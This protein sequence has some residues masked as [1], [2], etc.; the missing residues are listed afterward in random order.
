MFCC[1]TRE[2]FSTNCSS[3]IRATIP[4]DA[5]SVPHYSDHIQPFG[6]SATQSIDRPPTPNSFEEYLEY[7]WIH[8]SH[9][10]MDLEENRDISQLIKKF[11]LLKQCNQKLEENVRQKKEQLQQYK[12]LNFSIKSQ[13]LPEYTNKLVDTNTEVNN[14][15]STMSNLSNIQQQQLGETKPMSK[16]SVN[17]SLTN[18]LAASQLSTDDKVKEFVMTSQS[19]INSNTTSQFMNCHPK[20]GN[21]ITTQLSSGS[22]S[23]SGQSYLTQSVTKKS[24]P[25]THNNDHITSNSFRSNSQNTAANSLLSL[26]SN[27][28]L[29]NTTID[30]SVLQ[31]SSMSNGGYNNHHHV[32]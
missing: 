19:A 8:T 6:N 15:S 27:N 11:N 2:T 7:N 25:S 9:Y 26:A 3:S 29:L 28:P 31:L 13:L 24:N 32:P 21:N 4:F 5:L 17:S 14:T 30:T 12:L 16:N 23:T 22:V 20:L 18:L 10:L 1:L